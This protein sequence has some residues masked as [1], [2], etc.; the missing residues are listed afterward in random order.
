MGAMLGYITENTDGL[1]IPDKQF[2]SKILTITG[3]QMNAIF[4][5]I[6]LIMPILIIAL[7]V[8]VYARRKH[9]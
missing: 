8:I 5:I 6:V 2:V 7:G 1:V 3:A 9:L 4:I